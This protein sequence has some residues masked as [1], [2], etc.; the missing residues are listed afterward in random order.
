M[1]KKIEPTIMER[2]KAQMGFEFLVLVSQKEANKT[3]D[4]SCHWFKIDKFKY[5]DRANKIFSKNLL[6]HLRVNKMSCVANSMTNM[7]CLLSLV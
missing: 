5:N 7:G 3:W 2:M 1:Q 4:G 6:N